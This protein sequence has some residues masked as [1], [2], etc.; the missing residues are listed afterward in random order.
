MGKKADFIIFLDIIFIRLSIKFQKILDNIES[1]M[2][3]WIS[4]VLDYKKY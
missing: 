3:I 1:M 2:K 4:K